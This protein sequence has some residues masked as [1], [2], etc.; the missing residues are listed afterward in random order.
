MERN[1]QYTAESLSNTIEKNQSPAWSKEWRGILTQRAPLSGMQTS[2]RNDLNS[3]CLSWWS[4]WSWR[5]SQDCLNSVSNMQT[6][7]TTSHGRTSINIVGTTFT[8]RHL[9]AE[10][11]EQCLHA[12][13]YVL[14]LTC[15]IIEYFYHLIDIISTFSALTQGR[16]T[17]V[18]L[19]LHTRPLSLHP[20]STSASVFL[21]WPSGHRISC[22][23]AL[24]SI[25]SACMAKC[26]KQDYLSRFVWSG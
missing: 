10:T 17:H 11:C 22:A 5:Q 16:H 26:N 20:A 1:K 7:N 25:I 9:Q 12:C 15:S 8:H 2:C 3:W 13:M 21:K 4:R 14:C 23:W 6:S 19:G 18:K 24:F